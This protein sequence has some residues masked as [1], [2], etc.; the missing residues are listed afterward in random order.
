MSDTVSGAIF[1]EGFDKYG[2]ASVAPSNTVFPPLSQGGWSPANSGVGLSTISIEPGLDDFGY[3]V[4]FTLPASSQCIM[5]RTLPDNYTRL[6]GGFGFMVDNLDSTF[7]FSFFDVDMAQLSICIS[8]TVAGTIS[9]VLGNDLTMPL[10]QSAPLIAAQIRHYIEFDITFSSSS[11][12]GGWQVWL[13]GKQ[14]LGGTA[15][16]IVS[17]N[18][19]SNLVEFIAT[20][21]AGQTNIFNFDNMYLFQGT[22]TFNNSVVLANPVVVTQVPIGDFQT[23]LT[24]NG[25]ILGVSYTPDT[26]VYA[27]GAN[28]LFLMPVV[29]NVLCVT[30][31]LVLVPAATIGGTLMKPVMYADSAGKPG[32]LLSDGPEVTG[33]I[34]GANLF[35]SLS[36]PQVLFA[37]TKYWIGYIT[38]TGDSMSAVGSQTNGYRA[39]NTYS[40]GAP[41]PAPTMTPNQQS[42]V[43]YLA[44]LEAPS[45]WE[46][47]ALNPPLGEISSLGGVEDNIDFYIFPALPIHADQV[48]CVGVSV[49]AELTSAG[50]GDFALYVNSKGFT[51][52]FPISV[53]DVDPMWY[54]GYLAVDPGTGGVSTPT[55]ISNTFYGIQVID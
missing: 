17:T 36:T 23:Q 42:I 52:D 16:T 32:A 43:M 34:S 40:S 2:F 28:T 18:S 35:L 9:V 25:N 33:T 38:D 39:V 21:T 1:L 53:V 15:E 26:T 49:N 14:C 7:F 13:D 10:E 55:S 51:V 31:T 8:S 3:S 30:D 20:T 44:C 29:A 48:Y 46:S 19:Y 45:N 12:K 11:I 6:I 5:T 54:S 27:P 4:Q 50:V 22:E 47:L 37:E 41:D 24:N